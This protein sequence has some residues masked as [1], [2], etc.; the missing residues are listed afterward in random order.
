M[1][2]WRVFGR[3]KW[4]V[5]PEVIVE[6]DSADEAAE[7]AEREDLLGEAAADLFRDGSIDDE[8]IEIEDVLAAKE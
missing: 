6:A 7:I 5:T 2:R 1:T 4:T 3:V 8:D